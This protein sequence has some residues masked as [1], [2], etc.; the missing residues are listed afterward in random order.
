MLFFE[1][2]DGQL[3]KNDPNALNGKNGRKLLLPKDNQH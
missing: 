3:L 2:S 1:N